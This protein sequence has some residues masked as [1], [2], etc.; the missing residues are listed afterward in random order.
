[1]L[2]KITDWFDGTSSAISYTYNTVKNMLKARKLTIERIVK[3]TDLTKKQAKKT[4]DGVLGLV[5]KSI[6]E[7]TSLEN[8][9]R[10][11]PYSILEFMLNIIHNIRNNKSY[12]KEVHQYC[13]NDIE[14]INEMVNE[15][16]GSKEW[17][18]IAHQK[19]LN[20]LI[21]KYMNSF[22]KFRES[23]KYNG[24]WY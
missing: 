11:E 12:S 4:V 6:E 20:V 19:R 2:N 22:D 24:I 10:T 1:M 23:K 17:I 14:V 9:E 5:D 7:D 3:N 15:N 18:T 8:G 13:D 16:K 21:D